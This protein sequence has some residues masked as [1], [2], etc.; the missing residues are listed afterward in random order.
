M[1]RLLL[2]HTP[3]PIF[4]LTHIAC[5]SYFTKCRCDIA[6]RGV[7]VNNILLRYINIRRPLTLVNG[8]AIGSC[9]QVADDTAVYLTVTNKKYSQASQQDLQKLEQWE[10]TWEM[11][12]NSRKCQFM[13]ISRARNPIQTQYVLHGQV[14]EAVDHAKYIGL[15]I[16]H[17]LKWSHH[18][19][20]VTKPKPI[21]HWATYIEIYALNTKAYS[22]SISNISKAPAS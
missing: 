7:L 2:K 5:C 4:C 3:R 17:D 12:F 22:D 16:S 1:H 15:E 11:H 21:G 8:S 6:L 14:L 13:H 20:C 19:Q 18:I 10:K 9:F